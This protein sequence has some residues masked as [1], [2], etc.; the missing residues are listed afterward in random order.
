VVTTALVVNSCHA[1]SYRTQHPAGSRGGPALRPTMPRL[2]RTTS[3]SSP[4]LRIAPHPTIHGQI[5]FTGTVLASDPIS[6]RVS[7]FKCVPS[8]GDVRSLGHSASLGAETAQSRLRIS[9]VYRRSAMCAVLYTAPISVLK[10]PVH[11]PTAKVPALSRRVS[12]PFPRES[13]HN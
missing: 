6:V 4:L 5:E 3:P 9:K 13:R 8:L 12:S 2:F 1:D 11:R 7:H 10:L